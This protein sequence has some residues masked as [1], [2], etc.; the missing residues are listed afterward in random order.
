MAGSFSVPIAKR[1]AIAK[2]LK[3]AE[4]TVARHLSQVSKRLDD[5]DSL[6]APTVQGIPLEHLNP[7]KHTDALLA[8]SH[9]KRNIAAVA[10]EVGIGPNMAAK[11][12]KELDGELL[13]L[14]RAIEEVRIEDLTKRF[15]TLSRDA[16]D[17]ITPEKLARSNAQQLAIIAGVAVDKFQLLRGQPTQRMEIGD[18][19][20][21]NE[22]LGLIVKE[23]KRRGIEIDVT[24]EGSTTAKKS[25][26]RCMEQ[27]KEVK[28]IAAGGDPSM[29]PA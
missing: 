8:L 10:R 2:K 16:V 5:P 29:V 7:E 22:V 23:A 9:P 19:R 20:Q 14:S 28:A 24:P 21:L 6:A 3:V 18:R 4:S 11:L 26:Y 12:A 1:R 17:A 15:G 27:Q 25:P 13:P